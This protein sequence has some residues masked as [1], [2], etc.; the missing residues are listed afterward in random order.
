MPFLL[1]TNT[2]S[3]LAND[4]SGAAARR[5]HDGVP[6]EIVTSV[7]V[8][9]EIEYGLAKKQSAKLTRQ[10]KAI[11]AAIPMLA[12]RAPA[13]MVYGRIRHELSKAGIALSPNDMLIA[14]H[15]LALDAT[16]VTDDR[17][18]ERVPGLKVENWMR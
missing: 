7:I 3:Q 10:M 17:V 15:T 12:F 18:F 11:L 14:A 1:D 16:L 8:G 13:H 4:P 2:L 9:C 5:I 6:E